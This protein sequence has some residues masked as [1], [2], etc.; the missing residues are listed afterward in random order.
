MCSIK[1]NNIEVLGEI[2]EISPKVI[3][4]GKIWRN[5]EYVKSKLKERF[6]NADIFVKHMSGADEGR[7]SQLE[8]G[9]RYQILQI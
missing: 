9:A 6:P 7:I 1:N 5:N 4:Y 2:I 3:T 8:I